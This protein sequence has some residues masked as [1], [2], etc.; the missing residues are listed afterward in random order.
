[1]H[2]ITHGIAALTLLVVMTIGGGAG[3]TLDGSAPAPKPV[4][5]DARPEPVPT[6]EFLST[7]EPLPTP[8]PLQQHPNLQQRP[9]PGH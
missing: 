3:C 9:N 4:S 1:M 7:P 8:E 6:P 2:P 5:T